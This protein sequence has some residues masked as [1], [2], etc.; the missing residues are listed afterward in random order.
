MEILR[1]GP[2]ATLLAAIAI[3]LSSCTQVPATAPPPA[4]KP[5]QG[6]VVPPPIAD[7]QDHS[8]TTRTEIL[9]DALRRMSEHGLPVEAYEL[10]N[11]EALSG[12]ARNSALGKAWQL[13]AT[14]LARGYLNQE[15][16]QPRTVPDVAEVNMYAAIQNNGAEELATALSTLAPQH[17]SYLALRRELSRQQAAMEAAT[18]PAAKSRLLTQIN[19]LRVNLERW[20]WL[21]HDL[22][23]R[24]VLAN[25]ASFDV[26]TFEQETPTSSYAAIFGKAQRQTPIF[27]DEIEYIV[28]NPWWEIPDSIARK[29]KL[30]QFRQDP[31]AIT[32]LGYQVLDRQGRKVDPATIDWNAVSAETFPYRLRQAPGPQNALGQVKIMFPNSHNVYLHDT[33]DKSLFDSDERIFSSGCVRV[34]NP[35]D[36]AAWILK[37]TPG[38]DRMTIETVVASGDETRVD[39]KSVVPVYVVY[40]TTVSN[41]CGDVTYLKDI[42]GRD[43]AVLSA[44]Q[45]SPTYQN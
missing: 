2:M 34:Q 25:I 14:H 1:P 4:P 37:E 8:Q 35:L 17:P 7:E 20:R 42:Y 41:A 3:C 6:A 38:W 15:T 9:I 16:L 36:L 18:D 43:A 13:A 27:S 5:P 33:N 23:E 28:F 11:I 19:Q 22:G 39:L 10:E 21:P 40:M 31:A 44:L 26:T 45:P 32:R 29:D 12:E 30:T 24:S